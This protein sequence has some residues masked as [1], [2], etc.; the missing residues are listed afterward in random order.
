MG[1]IKT[2]QVKRVTQQLLK[3][4]REELTSDFVK[5]KEAVSRLVSIHSTKIRNVIAGYITRLVKADK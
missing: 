2:R 3:A 4:H 1:R 5:N